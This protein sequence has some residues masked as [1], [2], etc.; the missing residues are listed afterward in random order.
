LQQDKKQ[1]Q[2]KYV[3]AVEVFYFTESLDLEDKVELTDISRWCLISEH[4]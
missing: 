1:Q 4:V 2:R 3:N